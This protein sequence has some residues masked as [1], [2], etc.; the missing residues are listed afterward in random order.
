MRNILR[1]RK[2]HEAWNPVSNPN[3]WYQW[4]HIEG[5]LKPCASVPDAKKVHLPYLDVSPKTVQNIY[6]ASSAWQR[7]RQTGLQP[8]AICIIFSDDTNGWCSVTHS[9]VRWRAT[10]T[11]FRLGDCSLHP[12]WNITD[13][14]PKLNQSEGVKTIFLSICVQC[15]RQK[16]SFICCFAHDCFRVQLLSPSLST[17][18]THQDNKRPFC[19]QTGGAVSSIRPSKWKIANKLGFKQQV[20]SRINA[21]PQWCCF[22]WRRSEFMHIQWSY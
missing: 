16:R 22:V 19:N 3:K 20:Q 6:L 10:W 5:T 1:T 11:T 17:F 15:F 4:L 21:D 14:S 9:G 7:A 12:V 2:R 13:P 18:L 8:G